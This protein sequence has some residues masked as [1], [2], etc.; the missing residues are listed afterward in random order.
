MDV[1][2][3][4]VR[5]RER[6]RILADDRI[7]TCVTTVSFGGVGRRGFDLVQEALKSATGTLEC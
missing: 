5:A 2:F 3:V 4:G 7:S 1:R 6:A